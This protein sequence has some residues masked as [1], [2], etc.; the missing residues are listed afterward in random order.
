MTVSVHDEPI[1]LG[2]RLELF[3]DEPLVGSLDGA[4]LELGALRDEGPVFRFDREWEG[5]FFG[6]VFEF[7]FSTSA[8]GG[9]RVET[10]REDGTPVEGYTLDDCVEQ[11]GNEFDRRVTWKRE[12]G[13]TSDVSILAGES[14]RLRFPLIDA[15]LFAMRFSL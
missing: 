3:V 6:E 13:A 2:S 4:R 11:I 7:N 5:P 1:E 10:Q 8:A 14:V 9:V 15:D 12:G